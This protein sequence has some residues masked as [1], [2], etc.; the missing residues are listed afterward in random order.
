M[1]RR[2]VSLRAAVNASSRSAV[3]REFANSGFFT[4]LS[5]RIADKL[6]RRRKIDDLA[7]YVDKELRLEFHSSF[8]MAMHVVTFA[9]MTPLMYV[10][11]EGVAPPSKLALMFGAMK[12]EDY[13]K[14]FT[15]IPWQMCSVGH[16]FLFAAFYIYV[17]P[18]IRYPFFVHGL[19]PLFRRLGLVKHRDF[20]G[21]RRSA[22]PASATAPQSKSA[23]GWK[24]SSTTKR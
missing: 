5:A 11:T 23:A 12:R 6:A 4:R 10:V 7:D 17:T 15:W 14:L 13:D 2:S 22:A 24:S 16:A 9:L 21:T 18:Y 19:A 20:T 1:L 3:E 8:T